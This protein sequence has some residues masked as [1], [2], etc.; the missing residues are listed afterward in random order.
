MIVIINTAQNLPSQNRS[1]TKIDKICY[2]SAFSCNFLTKKGPDLL[3]TVING[4]AFYLF[5]IAVTTDCAKMVAAASRVTGKHAHACVCQGLW[6]VIASGS[7]RKAIVPI[8]I[9][10]LHFS[11][12]I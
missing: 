10:L 7:V 9:Y 2:F 12:T 3:S 5:R 4:P 11:F 6:E 1:L 8:V